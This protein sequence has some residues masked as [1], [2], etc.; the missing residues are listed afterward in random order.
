M[1]KCINQ[2]I[3]PKLDIKIEGCGDCTKCTTDELNKNCKLYYP[4]EF[5][6]ISETNSEFN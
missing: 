6:S 4:V 3:R 5:F 2:I 1:K